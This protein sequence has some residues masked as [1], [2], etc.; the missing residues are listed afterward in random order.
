MLEASTKGAAAVREACRLY[1]ELEEMGVNI[2]IPRPTPEFSEKDAEFSLGWLRFKYNAV[3]VA[4]ELET[5]RELFK[6]RPHVPMKFW[7]NT[8]PKLANPIV[9]L[10][11]SNPPTLSIELKPAEELD[12]G[13]PAAEGMSVGTVG[14]AVEGPPVA[15]I[16]A[17]PTGP[18]R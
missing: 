15:K 3:K 6:A 5:M 18:D 17:E 12:L 14:S 9:Y 13:L 16:I 4:A 10:P 7:F 11:F 8:N 2:S 1:R